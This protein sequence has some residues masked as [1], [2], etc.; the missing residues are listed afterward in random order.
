[1]LSG[2]KTITNE[3]RIVIKGYLH[4]VFYIPTNRVGCASV[5]VAEE[6]D[7][8]QKRKAWRFYGNRL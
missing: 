7:S 1:M 6:E 2:H 5:D 3:F 4:L 8:A